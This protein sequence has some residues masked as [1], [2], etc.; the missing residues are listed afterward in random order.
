MHTCMHYKILIK[1]QNV[2][3]AA[4]FEEIKICVQDIERTIL[5]N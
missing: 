5:I 2:T 4:R 3:Q 1:G